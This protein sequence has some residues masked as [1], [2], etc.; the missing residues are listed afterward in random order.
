MEISYSCY[1]SASLIPCLSQQPLGA[2]GE[3]VFLILTEYV[4]S[5][6]PTCYYVEICPFLTLLLL[7][8]EQFSFI[9]IRPSEACKHQLNVNSWKFLLAE[10]QHLSNSEDL[11]FLFINKKNL[12]LYFA[13]SLYF[14]SM[15]FSFIQNVHPYE[16]A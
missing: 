4:D 16:A 8:K 15:F 9:Q 5:P 14:N 12:I 1:C 6:T 11:Y 3:G 7:F 10:Q 13:W 2:L